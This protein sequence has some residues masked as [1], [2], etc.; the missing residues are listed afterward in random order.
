MKTVS[1]FHQTVDDFMALGVISL[2]DD[3][4]FL[5]LD[6]YK[7]LNLEEKKK[8][9][10]EGNAVVE[11]WFGNSLEDGVYEEEDDEEEMDE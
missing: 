9:K 2:G 4:S 7:K 8:K 3:S 5:R 11:G 6:I 1:F 10:K